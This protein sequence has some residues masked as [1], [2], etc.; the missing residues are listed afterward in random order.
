MIYNS[1]IIK[2]YTVQI[3]PVP[4]HKQGIIVAIAIDAD[5]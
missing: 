1:R 3:N 5:Q 2:S 4:F